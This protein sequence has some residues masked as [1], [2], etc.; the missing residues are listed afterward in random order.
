MTFSLKSLSEILIEVELNKKY[1]NVK[2]YDGDS[3]SEF[4]SSILGFLSVY[5]VSK[6]QDQVDQ[7]VSFQEYLVAR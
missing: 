4:G 6:S 2:I 3:Y 5:R 7:L 1:R